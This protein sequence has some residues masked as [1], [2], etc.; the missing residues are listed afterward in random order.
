VTLSSGSL[1]ADEGRIPIA[2]PT[3]IAAQGHYILT[4][5]IQVSGSAGIVVDATHVTIDLNGH[6]ISTALTTNHLIEMT[7]TADFVTVRNGR[8]SGGYNAI[9]DN[10]TIGIAVWM[11]DL[12]IDG[13]AGQGISLQGAAN[14]E[15]LNSRL[16][17]NNVAMFV[18]G[19]SGQFVTGRIVGN[20]IGGGAA[21]LALLHPQ[22]MQI[23]DNMI[24]SC[25]NDGIQ[26]GVSSV[27]DYGGNLIE[28]NTI[29]GCTVGI[30][31]FAGVPGN[32][33]VG[34]VLKQNAVGIE[35]ASASNRIAENTIFGSNSSAPCG[36]GLCIQGP[37]NLIEGN[38][39]GGTAPGC[40]IR[41]FGASALNNAYRNNM[42]R[43][44]PGG[45]ICATG[46]GT[47]TDAG[48]NIF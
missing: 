7:P 28:H 30:D 8:L 14:V 11:E 5:D 13:A 19:L 35:C 15:L 10:S 33:V 36:G 1:R 26:V 9:Y 34:N 18:Q 41:F 6:I 48:G 42:L 21:C 23:R 3:T 20:T 2:G 16:V 47:A 46:G 43:N 31:I 38:A 25:G 29:S 44:N 22:D 39:I 17:N 32:Q 45:Q 27:P 37:S 4:R 24:T 12:E 40:A